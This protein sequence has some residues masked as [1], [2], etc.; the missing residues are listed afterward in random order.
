MIRPL[1]FLVLICS[2]TCLLRSADEERALAPVEITSVLKRSADW[3]LANPLGDTPVTDWVAAPLYDGLLRLAFTTGDEKYLAAV[4]ARGQQVGWST[5]HR[6]L[7]ADDIAVGHAWLDVYLLDRTNAER[8]GPTKKHLDTILA[9]PCKEDLDMA[10]PKRSAKYVPEARWTWCD[11]LYMAPPTFSRLYQATGDKRY[12]EFMDEEYRFTYDRLWDKEERLFFRDGNF[13]AKRSP[14]GKKIFWS[15]GNGWVFGGLALLLETLPADWPTRPFYENLFREMCVSV[16]AAQQADGLWT[17]SLL[18]P[19]QV[20]VGETSGSAFFVFGLSWGLNHGYF[21]REKVWPAIEKGWKGLLTRLRPDGYVGYVQRIGLA[22]DSV[23]ADSRQDYGTGALLLA[24]S[25]LLRL[26]KAD[27]PPADKVAF[28][29]KAELQAQQ[30]TPRAYVKLVPE[31]KDDIAWENDKVAFRLYGP[32]LRDSIEDSGID[33]WCKRVPYPILD[34]WYAL[35]NAGKLSYHED[36]GEGYDG[37]KVADSLGCGGLGILKDGVLV[38]SDV[39]VEHRILETRPEEARFRVL[40]RYPEIDGRRI[41]EVRYITLR[42]GERVFELR[43]Q[44]LDRATG[45]PIAGLKVAAGLFAQTG[46]SDYRFDPAS[47]VM[48]LADQL[49]AALLATGLAV[50]PGRV[51]GMERKAHGK[52]GQ[53]ALCLMQT[54]AEGRVAYKAGYAWSKAGDITTVEAWLDYLKA[55]AK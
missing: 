50:A 35:D 51:L 22:P 3:Q 32:A 24:G 10:Y 55:R 38:S 29:R 15:R 53:Q 27:T 28:L 25:E 41:E 2:F 47:G 1:C 17:P 33:V 34:K 6:I 21:E 40:Y 19:A 49:D 18:D 45:K 16:L 23:N 36:H 43:S 5:H 37:Y 31:R 48:V 8:L 11:A 44:F 46:A 54:D 26:L 30:K 39:Y 12:L 42:L 9:A 14:A 4:L 52:D 13:P 7:H 20:R